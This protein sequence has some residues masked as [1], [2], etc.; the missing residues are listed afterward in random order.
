MPSTDA[1][2]ERSW[3]IPVV[4]IEQVLSTPPQAV[5]DLRSPSEFALDHVPGAT[6]HHLFDDLERQLIGTLYAKESPG[7]AFDEGRERV[8]QRI[9]TLVGELAQ[10]AGRELPDADL[11]SWVEQLT[12]GGIESVNR[13]L[14][15]KR[16]ADLPAGAIVV[17]CWRGGLRSSSLAVLLRA[18]GW[19]DVY[20]LE[21]G[22]KSYRTRVLAELDAWKAPQ[23]IILRGCTGVGKTLLLREI[24]RLRPG[25]TLDLEGAAGHRSSILG[26]VGLEPC[27]QKT[28]DSRLATRLRQG[29]PGLMVVEGESR[30]VGDSIVPKSIWDALQDGLQLKLTAS[31]EQR[32]KVLMEDYLPVEQNREPL[33]RQLPFIETR[34]GSNKWDGVLVDLFDSGREEELVQI[35]LEQYY[36]PLYNHSEIGRSHAGELDTTNGLEAAATIVNWIE[37]RVQ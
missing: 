14:T 35:L 27:N 5:F 31:M 3:T 6:N 16:Q 25:W 18:I 33:R 22:Y 13:A 24:E 15:T 32:V 8:L 19:D 30:K 1:T 28:F 34:L 7:A 26:M 29:F 11:R 21:G 9:E 23:T 2:Q 36:D 20:V 37:G 4:T 10:S 17:H 12:R